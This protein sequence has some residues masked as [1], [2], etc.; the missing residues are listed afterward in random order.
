MVCYLRAIYVQDV[1][2]DKASLF[3]YDPSTKEFY[4]CEEE[5]LRYSI[6]D[7]RKDSDWLLFIVEED[8]GT[9]RVTPVKSKYVK[10][11]IKRVTIG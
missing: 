7:I 6:D 8:Y 3:E 1:L 9:Q 11:Y 10:D 5:T 4:C 2:F